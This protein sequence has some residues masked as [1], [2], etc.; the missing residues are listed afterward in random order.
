[1]SGFL[2]VNHHPRTTTVGAQRTWVM[3]AS[4]D[5]ATRERISGWARD[6]Q[7]TDEPVALQ[8]LDNGQP[9]ARVLANL[10]RPDLEEAGFGGRHGFDIIVPGGLSPLARHVI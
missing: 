9:I 1:M 8:I 3:K 7:A 2:E 6:R 4:V 5:V 10:H